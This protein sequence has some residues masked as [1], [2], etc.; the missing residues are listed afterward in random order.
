M[1]IIAFAGDY[2]TLFELPKK[3]VAVKKGVFREIPLISVKIDIFFIFY[4]TIAEIQT[5]N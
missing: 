5:Y 1:D 3:K 4:W 2:L